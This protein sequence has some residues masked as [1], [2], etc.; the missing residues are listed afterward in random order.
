MTHTHL[1]ELLH[2]GAATI[3]NLCAVFGRQAL[4]FA[5][6]WTATTLI[7]N[8]NSMRL[9]RLTPVHSY[10]SWSLAHEAEKKFNFLG[11][12]LPKSSERSHGRTLPPTLA[13]TWCIPQL[14]MVQLTWMFPKS[15]DQRKLIM[16]VKLVI[17]AKTCPVFYSR[18][19]SCG[20]VRHMML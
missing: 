16:M 12:K 19:L 14:T 7:F 9:R 6:P 4:K 10:E 8:E 13:N 1:T 5:C 18:L 15:S 2:I 3:C 20:G 17:E 11:I